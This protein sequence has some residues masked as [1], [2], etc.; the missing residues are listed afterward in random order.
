MILSLYSSRINTVHYYCADICILCIRE[1][2]VETRTPIA[3]ESSALF[4]SR[5]AKRNNRIGD[6]RSWM[7]WKLFAEFRTTGIPHYVAQCD[8]DRNTGRP[9]AI[10][11]S[12]MKGARDFG[13]N[14][15]SNT[16]AEKSSNY[17]F[18]ARHVIRRA[19]FAT[20]FFFFYFSSC[21]RFFG[22]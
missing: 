22:S 12:G 17:F 6:D 16:S 5:R 20:M 21:E 9:A 2:T 15:F 10:H 1:E 7:R 8:R 3:G 11:P 18:L 19:D 14:E 4:V 13:S